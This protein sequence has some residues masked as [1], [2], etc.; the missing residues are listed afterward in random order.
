MPQK[1]AAFKANVDQEMVAYKKLKEIVGDGTPDPEAL[2][3]KVAERG[4]RGPMGPRGR[5]GDF[6]VAGQQGPPG[7]PG[8]PGETPELLRNCIHDPHAA[9][10]PAL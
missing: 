7:P 2:V 3:V 5:R 6:G 8:P 1:L 9:A 10:R 4:P